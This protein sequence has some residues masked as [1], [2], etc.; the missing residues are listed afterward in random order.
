MP[1]KRSPSEFAELRAQMNKIAADVVSDV[2]GRMNWL[3]D[4]GR[5]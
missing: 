2:G 3:G 4:L 1:G 5:A